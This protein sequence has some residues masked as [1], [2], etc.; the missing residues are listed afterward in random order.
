MGQV[1]FWVYQ[2]AGAT[3]LVLSFF[4]VTAVSYEQAS[5]LPKNLAFLNKPLY[6]FTKAAID[7]IEEDT[8]AQCFPVNFAISFRVDFFAYYLWATPSLFKFD[9]NGSKLPPLHITSTELT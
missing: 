1:G 3:N 6:V 5:Q 4:V 2:Q 7:F 9:N 8:L